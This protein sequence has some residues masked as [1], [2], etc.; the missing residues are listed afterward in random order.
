MDFDDIQRGQNQ[1]NELKNKNR[2]VIVIRWVA[3]IL[4]GVGVALMMLFVIAHLFSPEGYGSPAFGEA[5]GLFF[6]P[7]GVCLGLIIAWKWEGLGGLVAVGSIIGFHLTM[8]AVGGSLD[9]NAFI[10]GFA[11][12][13][14]LFLIAWFLSRASS[15]LRKTN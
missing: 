15:G 11:V 7:F 12:P 8:L 4:G 6:F 9:I 14:L 13:G 5:V 3:R 10:D 1:M 2:I